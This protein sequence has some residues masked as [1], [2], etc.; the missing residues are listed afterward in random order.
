MESV[1]SSILVCAD[2]VLFVL[3]FMKKS[4]YN[5]NLIN[6]NGIWRTRY[7]NELYTVYDA[8]DIVKVVKLGRLRCL[9]HLIRMQELNPCRKLT[10]LNQKVLYM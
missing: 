1:Q 10:L 6:D 7:S 4:L 2:D 9:G 8:L 5:E 3:Q